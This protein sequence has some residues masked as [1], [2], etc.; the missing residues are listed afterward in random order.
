MNT[1]YSLKAQIQRLS[2]AVYA[3]HIRLEE[4]RAAL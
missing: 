3:Y 2:I 1:K 4:P